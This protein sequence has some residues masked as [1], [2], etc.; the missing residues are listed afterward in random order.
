MGAKNMK[1]FL[2]IGIVFLSFQGNADSSLVTSTQA[3]SAGATEGELKH[4]LISGKNRLLVIGLA[5]EATKASSPEARVFV[6]GQQLA[7]LP[8]ARA[9]TGGAEIL[10][11]QLFMMNDQALSGLTRVDIKVVMDRPVSGAVVSA[12]SMA[13]VSDQSVI[14]RIQTDGSGADMTAAMTV[15][16][17]AVT[18]MHTRANRLALSTLDIALV[19]N[20]S[21]APAPAPAPVPAPAPAPAPVPAPAPA[22]APDPAPDASDLL[23][24]AMVDGSTT[25]GAGGRAVTVRTLADLRAA[26]ALSEP[27]V[28][29][30]E[31][32]LKG[33]E[34]IAVASNKTIVG[35]GRQATLSG[36]GLKIGSP[37]KVIQNVII[38]NLNFEKVLAPVDG[39]FITQKAHHVWVDHCAFSS[40]L[41]HGKD[42]YDGLLD[43]THAADY[44][45]VSWN[46]FERHY[47]V[48]LI[49]H[50]DS[51]GAEDTGHLRVTYHHNLFK[52]VN[53]RNASMRFGRGH[54]FN[55]Y[56][57]NVGGYGL[58]ARE[59]AEIVIENNVFEN[60]N[61]PIAADTSLSSVAG[62]VRGT[63]SNIY[64]RSG[65]NSIKTTPATWVIP[66]SYRLA[67]AADVP[68][69]ILK[70]AGP[71]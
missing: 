40:D 2:L 23:G 49:G 5:L 70:S 28:I 6:G 38:R 15:R 10:R 9:R 52:D 56:Y 13:N 30:I 16:D 62:R 46:T 26:A 45:T 37:S 7:E 18:Y 3:I 24:M 31:G 69:L 68:S 61:I 36:V 4:T 22:P 57:L 1:A 27:L 59:N 14:A 58:A 35:L 12:L 29:E 42:Y 11:T 43:I 25:G 55:N 41:E 21:P 48:S 39:V 50:S 33:N 47:K 65:A 20:E 44:V 17:A 64:V 51:N 60:T 53:S 63:E 34:A 67:P 19:G 54:F 32:R 66:Y 71:Q 8:S